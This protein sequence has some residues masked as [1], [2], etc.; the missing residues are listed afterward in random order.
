MKTLI[1]CASLTLS[2]TMLFAYNG[3]TSIAPHCPTD[4]VP[5]VGVIDG[6][7]SSMAAVNNHQANTPTSNYYPFKGLFYFLFGKR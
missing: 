5:H 7:S 4:K 2:T 1:L 3:S 6:G